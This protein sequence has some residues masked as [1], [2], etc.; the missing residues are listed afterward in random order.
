[1]TASVSRPKAALAAL[2]AVAL[3]LAGCGGTVTPHPP[4]RSATLVSGGHVAARANACD[5]GANAYCALDV[6]FVDPRFASAQALV[7][8]E[9]QWL[10]RNGWIKVSAQTGDEVAADSPG[11]RL[12]V[13]YATAS[14]D[15]KDIDL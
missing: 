10:K 11:D 3:A 15:L 9:R 1:M 4:L 13:T 2:V 7:T 6:V 14:L 8:N 5:A 12:R